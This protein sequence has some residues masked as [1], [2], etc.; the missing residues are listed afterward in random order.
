M[1]RGNGR[2]DGSDQKIHFIPEQLAHVRLVHR[3]SLNELE[4]TIREVRL[5][6]LVCFEWRWLP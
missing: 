5:E 1:R 4:S 6:L 3:V 2:T